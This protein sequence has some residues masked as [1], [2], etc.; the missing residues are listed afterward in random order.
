[1]DSMLYSRQAS[2]EP[3][4]PNNRRNES[5]Q[6]TSNYYNPDSTPS[7]KV[8][9]SKSFTSS[10]L[11]SDNSNK[12]HPISPVS[13][14]EGSLSGP[15]RV[16]GGA[17][18]GEVKNYEDVPPEEDSLIQILLPCIICGRTFSPA[19]L[20]R[21]SKVCVKV[22]EEEKVKCRPTYDSHAQRI[23]NTRVADFIP[24]P[25]PPE[26]ELFCRNSRIR[27]S[28]QGRESFGKGSSPMVRRTRAASTPKT[29]HFDTSDIF[30]ANSSDFGS[31]EDSGHND[32]NTNGKF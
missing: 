7:W 18:L 1:M 3:P 24:P 6:E 32:H 20:E 15:G 12:K 23:K 14:E 4:N 10:L 21:H 16:S 8:P 25:E 28:L 19:A 17:G 2:F 27:R 31:S 30:G 9:I 22:K 29:L 13:E 11:F 26:A 5:E